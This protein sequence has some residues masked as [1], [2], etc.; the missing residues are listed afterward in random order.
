MTGFAML[1]S[2]HDTSPGIV[3]RGRPPPNTPV[4]ADHFGEQDVS[5]GESPTAP[6][7]LVETLYLSI[8]PY[9]RCRFNP[10]TGVDYTAPFELGK[11]LT[12]GGIGYVLDS[13]LP[14]F[15]SGDIV[16]DPFD[17]WPWQRVARIGA[18]HAKRLRVLP[19][20]LALLC[21]LH[22]TLG[23]LG[24][25]GLTA[26]F[27]ML[28]ECPPRPG[29][30]VVVSGA[31]GAV[32]SVAGQLARRAG[33]RVVGVTGDDEKCTV[34]TSGLGFD[35]AVNHRHPSWPDTLAER[36][37]PAGARLYFDNVGG[38][39]SDAVIPHLQDKGHVILCG[40]SATYDSDAP[41]PPPLPPAVQALADRRGITRTRFLVSRYASRFPDASR[42]LLSLVAGGQLVAL[43]QVYRGVRQAPNAFL[44]LM[45]G[46]KVGKQIVEVIPPPL[47][48]S[49]LYGAARPL[50]P[51]WARSWLARRVRF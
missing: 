19:P 23:C 39:I 44:D 18:D 33:C 32:G 31:T 2:S 22:Y 8:D 49:R 34:L 40:Q 3:L 35:A 13:S 28:H 26:Y 16:L 42:E 4:T 38:P 27:G 7:L 51:S 21:P 17:G 25:T 47:S 29:D 6:H 5:L 24:L 10:Q 48:R 50:V 43:D 15:A 30:C 9:L 36:V 37:G 14:G 41:Y 12:S 45:E 46:R 11:P 20:A 1:S